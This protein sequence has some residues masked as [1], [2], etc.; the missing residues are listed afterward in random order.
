METALLCFETEGS[1]MPDMSLLC[2]A[3]HEPALRAQVVRRHPLSSDCPPHDPR[4]FLQRPPT[5]S[6]FC[7]TSTLAPAVRGCSVPSTSAA[8][9]HASVR[10]VHG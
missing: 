6:S 1:A 4:V 5:E 8:S 9:S 7:A 2:H 10:A 3:G